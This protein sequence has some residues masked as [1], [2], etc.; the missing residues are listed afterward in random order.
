MASA[1]VV[2]LLVAAASRALANLVTDPGFESCTTDGA[3]PPPGWT[4]TALC[5]TPAPHS[6]NWAAD[7]SSG[8]M[9]SHS[10]ATTAGDM[11]EFSFWLRFEASQSN[12]FTAAFG[13]DVV[14]NLTNSNPTFSYIFEDFTVT[15]AAASTTISFTGATQVG[16]WRLDD[17][18][19]T[20]APEPATLPV[21]SSARSFPFLAPDI[22]ASLGKNGRRSV[23]RPSR[24]RPILRSRHRRPL[25]GASRLRIRHFSSCNQR[26]NLMITSC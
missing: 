11:Y 20:A 7:F 23:V 25:E 4:G 2:S 9:L 21:G 26:Y 19:V 10:M 13:P 12:S 22:P 24:P 18:S 3:A 5:G 16:F 8:Q 15:A 1:L 6:G 17:V 14:L